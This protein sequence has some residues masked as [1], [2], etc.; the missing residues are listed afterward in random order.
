MKLWGAGRSVWQI[1]RVAV[2]SLVAP[3]LEP[4]V[5]RPEVLHALRF[6]PFVPV[7]ERVGSRPR[8]DPQVVRVVVSVVA[9]DVVDGLP[10]LEGAA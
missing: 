6:P 7:Q 10:R 2:M 5:E 4:L 9:V 1:A 3:K 8:Q